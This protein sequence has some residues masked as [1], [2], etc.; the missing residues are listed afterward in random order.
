M[1]KTGF[2]WKSSENFI[3]YP[4]LS[5]LAS[6][7]VYSSFCLFLTLFYN[8]CFHTVSNNPPPPPVSFYSNIS[9]VSSTISL[10]FFLSIRVVSRPS[11]FTLLEFIRLCL[12]LVNFLELISFQFFTIKFASHVR[13]N[14]FVPVV[15][16]R[17]KSHGIDEIGRIFSIRE[18]R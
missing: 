13:L 15:S 1:L 16:S 12:S 5:R 8:T 2:K 3:L 18:N 17:I 6:R 4:Y 7:V 11:R 14:I 10:L 9:P